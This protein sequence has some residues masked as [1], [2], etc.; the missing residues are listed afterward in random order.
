MLHTRAETTGW[1]IILLA[2]RKGGHIWETW[3]VRPWLGRTRLEA[4]TCPTQ[5]WVATCAWTSQKSH[6]KT[7]LLHFRRAGVL[8]PEQ[9]PQ[10]TNTISKSPTL[11]DSSKKGRS[12]TEERGKGGACFI[13]F[14]GFFTILN[15]IK[16]HA[17]IYINY[18]GWYKWYEFFDYFLVMIYI[19]SC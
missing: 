1:K 5:S 2:P 16:M 15:L 14:Q 11:F 3:C 10:H 8:K 12:E 17:C 9:N 4:M 19:D 18:M 7:H 13:H 6:K